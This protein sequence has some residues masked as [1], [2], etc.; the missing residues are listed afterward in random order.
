MAQMAATS[1]EPGD[2]P[3]PL[4]TEVQTQTSLLVTVY[5]CQGSLSDGLSCGKGVSHSPFCILS[6]I[7]R[8]NMILNQGFIMASLQ[9]QKQLY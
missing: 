3:K 6:A 8:V 2:V 1:P 5:P 7:F 4:T 9:W